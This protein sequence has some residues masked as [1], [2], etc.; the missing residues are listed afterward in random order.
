MSRETE[1]RIQRLED[2]MTQML[3]AFLAVV[4]RLDALEGRNNAV[5]EGDEIPAR[6]GKI[7]GK[8]THG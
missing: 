8:K 7:K 4:E 5:L 2:H 1:N 3:Q 6:N